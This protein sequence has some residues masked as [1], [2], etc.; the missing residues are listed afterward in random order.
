[1]EF[2]VE[3]REIIPVDD[4]QRLTV[5]KDNNSEIAIIKFNQNDLEH[6]YESG[7]TKAFAIYKPQ[8]MSVQIPKLCE[9]DDTDT[10]RVV[11]T[12]E[13]DDTANPVD[14]VTEWQ[15]VFTN[16]DLTENAARVIWATLIHKLKI[17]RSLIA[18]M[19]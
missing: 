1:M 15:I 3:N 18:E 14:G 6:F 17:P 4:T 11:V 9:I 8:G 13:I 5:Q 16:D 2:Y 7:V 12:W 10:G 19:E